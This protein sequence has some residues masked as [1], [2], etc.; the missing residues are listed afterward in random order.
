MR[1]KDY[2]TQNV[3][4]IQPD[5]PLADAVNLM[6]QNDFH[7]LPVVDQDKI[8]QGLITEKII[9]ENTP[10]HAS[11]LSIYEMNY[12]LDKIKVSEILTTEAGTISQEETIETAAAKMYDKAYTVLTVLDHGNQ[13]IGIITDKDI[14]AAMIELTGYRQ[15]GARVEI[16]VEDRP[17][18][19]GE[20][21]KLFG[22]EKI[23]IS[24]VFVTDRSKDN[25]QVK[26]VVQT[27][28]A[29]EARVIKLLE[30]AGYQPNYLG[31]Y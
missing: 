22:D 9:A 4:T 14:F 10:S 24:H 23:S 25:K 28:D 20:V 1:V 26:I 19:L 30:E 15:Q 27:D 18:V 8:Y 17:G 31:S 12:L 13:V 5:T 16:P 3:I 21:A 6:G 7:Q 2:M 11:S 29:D